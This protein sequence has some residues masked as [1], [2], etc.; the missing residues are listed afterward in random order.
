MKRFSRRFCIA[1][2]IFV[3]VSILAPTIN[4]QCQACKGAEDWPKT[5][6]NFLTGVSTEEVPPS[7]SPPQMNR[8]NDLSTKGLSEDRNNEN[9]SRI[10]VPISGI[11]QSDI[12]I[13]ISPN[14]TEYIPGAVSIPYTM[15]IED[16]WQLKSAS[17][18]AKILV[19]A[20]ISQDDSL[21][22]YGECQ[23]CGGGPSASTYVYWLM[24]YLGHENIKLL[25]GGI[26]DWIAANNSTAV[27]P[28]ILQAKNYTPKLRPELLSTYEYV[29]SGQAQVLDARTSEEFA[30]GSIPGAINI[31]Y[32][33][34][35]NNG[36]I[37]EDY[38]LREIFSG[39][40]KDK[41]V[42]IY[43]NTGIKASMPW[44]VLS[45][46][47]YDAR[48]YSYQDWIDYQPK[49]EIDLENISAEPNPAKMGDVVRITAIF[50]ETNQ[51]GKK[52]TNNESILT[53]KGCATCGF[54]SPH[55]F[56]DITKPNG[57]AGV[58]RIGSSA[59]TPS[60]A[61]ENQ[62]SFQC[63]A[64]IFSPSGNLVSKVNMKRVKED[65]FS[66]IW[67]AN[68][69]SGNYSVSIMTSTPEASKT[70]HNVLKIEVLGPTSKYKNSG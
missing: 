19:A 33:S 30:A 42:V 3:I 46:L 16:D 55:G 18:M 45:L 39:L 67:N 22:I 5:A 1:I 31:P 32:D 6:A 64:S 61:T 69:A 20:G 50:G 37:K 36:R 43:T 12:I 47:G 58:V 53:I 51:T 21:L 27:E 70:F 26:N 11:K 15:F 10:L 54:G 40:S 56:A 13:D 34:I 60:N 35:L 38:K 48:L 4:A 49:L 28:K 17:E 25:D 9:F 44:F 66:G 59:R 24:K 41:P 63:A 52:E 57:N 7:L 68:V 14:A 2:S 65:V 8:L 23:P 62:D 29:K